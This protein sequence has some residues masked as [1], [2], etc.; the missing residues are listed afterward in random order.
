MGF[1]PGYN[2]KL[3]FNSLHQ[4]TQYVLNFSARTL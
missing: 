2:R 1:P 3:V 4:V